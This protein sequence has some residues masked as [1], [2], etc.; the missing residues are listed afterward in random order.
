MG[1][2]YP[3]ELAVALGFT[4]PKTPCA[5]T[6]H[7]CFK[8]L[9]IGALEKILNE[10]AAGVFATIDAEDKDAVAIDGKTLCGSLTQDAQITHLLSVM[11]HQLGIPLTQRSVP[12][13]TNEI[14]IATRILEAFDVAGKV[15][16]TDA[17]LTQRK[18]FQ[19]LCD[20]N[21]DYVLPVKDNQRKLLEDIRSVFE[22]GSSA[23]HTTANH[24]KTFERTLDDLGAHTDIYSTIE[25][26]NG[27]LQ[28]RTM[29]T[30]T[31][32]IGYRVCG[33]AGTCTSVS[34]QDKLGTH[35]HRKKDH[36]DTIWHNKFDT[37]VW[38]SR[39]DFD[40]SSWALDD[41]EP[42]ASHTG[43]VL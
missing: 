38:V 21:A 37:C 7:Y 22:P 19:D 34:I 6:F 43:C 26:E 5:S 14:P 40:A 9:D 39:T 23:T 32:L 30:S 27:W 42:V 33:V 25:K 15:V 17:L 2:T 20:A 29:T 41:R 12:D 24:T 13:K 36:Y 28:T 4:H 1:R 8:D 35:P 31:I 10:W 16:T 11:S 3:P 18:F